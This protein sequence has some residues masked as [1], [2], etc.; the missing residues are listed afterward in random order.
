MAY[1]LGHP[2]HRRWSWSTYNWIIWTTVDTADYLH[3]SDSVCRH[4]LTSRPTNN[5]WLAYKYEKL[6]CLHW[7]RATLAS[8]ARTTQP[9]LVFLYD[10]YATL[11]IG[12]VL[13]VAPRPSLRPSG[14][15]LLLN[16]AS[17]DG[18]I[19][20]ANA[21]R[22]PCAGHVLGFMSI[23]VVVMRADRPRLL[24]WWPQVGR[25]D[26]GSPIPAGWLAGCS[27][28]LGRYSDVAGVSQ[29][30]WPLRVY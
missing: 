3:I 17:Y 2:V 7:N 13:S 1:F 30:D 18:E 26:V 24:L 25:C 6:R 12:A 9:L 8:I 29:S 28:A 10:F 4:P 20:H 22:W 27:S 23:G 19:L 21:C 14:A 11:T 5:N 16:A 15:Y